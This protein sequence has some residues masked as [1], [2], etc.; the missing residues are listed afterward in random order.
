MARQAAPEIEAPVRVTKLVERAT[1]VTIRV[2]TGNTTFAPVQYN[3]FQ[4]GGVA[5]EAEFP[6]GTD[7]AAAIAEL[8]EIARA[9]FKVMYA[10][11]LDSYVKAIRYND[12]KVREDAE[13]R[14][15]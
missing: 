8:D 7:V 15:S 2:E 4:V 12:K 1:K 6:S 14:R 3:S 9:H 11:K 10:Y 13:S 5:I